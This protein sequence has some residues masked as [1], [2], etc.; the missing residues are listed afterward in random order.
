MAN[1]SIIHELDSIY[2]IKNIINNHGYNYLS[3]FRN[4]NY[5]VPKIFQNS[6]KEI[7]FKFINIETLMSKLSKSEININNIFYQSEESFVG[8]GSMSTSLSS[9]RSLLFSKININYNNIYY[10]SQLINK[11]VT[12]GNYFPIHNINFSTN[13]FINKN[14]KIQSISIQNFQINE[15]NHY[16]HLTNKP[17]LIISSL[18][19]GIGIIFV[20][21]IG[22]TKKF[23]KI[24]KSKTKKEI[25]RDLKSRK[26]IS[27]PESVEM[28]TSRNEAMESKKQ[29]SKEGVMT[30]RKA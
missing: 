11:L 17:H 5:I 4:K 7:N 24:T 29:N 28:I 22:V 25:K 12:A 16:K 10:Y 1:L 15:N 13:K 26:Q 21:I 30:N 2:N 27:K 18:L 3:Y 9:S 6:N 14:N 8:L 23:Y 20:A 19:C